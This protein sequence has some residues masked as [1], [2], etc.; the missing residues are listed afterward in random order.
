MLQCSAV[1]CRVGVGWGGGGTSLPLH[2]R[3]DM[4]VKVV[5]I[6]NLQWVMSNQQL[7]AVGV[8]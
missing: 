8:C 5:Q 3:P 7:M 2:V 6:L 1:Q 4:I